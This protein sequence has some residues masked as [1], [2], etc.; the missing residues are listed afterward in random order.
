MF[1]SQLNHRTKKDWATTVL[2][3]MEELNLNVT[4]EDIQH[5]S[6]GNWK[7]IV[8]RNIRDRALNN[9]LEMKQK[10]S[11]VMELKHEKM[12]IQ[13]YFL[14]N[15][16]ECTKED[17]Q[18]IFRIRSN[19]T[20]VKMNRKKMFKSH[21]CSKCF[22]ENETQEHV[23]NCN[24]IWEEMGEKQENYP[25]FDRIKNGQRKDQ[26]KIAKIFKEILKIVEKYHDQNIK[27][28]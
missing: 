3:D 2:K 11:K 17:I 8:K 23:Y 13:S 6:K 15:K 25:K 12:E 9:L 7:N 26:I 24:E 18:L 1:E 28:K 10:H 5:M 27:I 21:E 20:N 19:M 14:P 16:M 22:K 4:F